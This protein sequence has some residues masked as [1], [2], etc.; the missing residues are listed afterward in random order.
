MLS[1]AAATDSVPRT[2]KHP[3]FVYVSSGE[4]REIGVYRMED[5]GTLRPLAR[6]AI[7]GIVGPL[8]VSP[9]RTHLYAACRSQPF[10]VHVYAIDA[11]TGALTHRSSAPL[12]NSFPYIAFDRTGRFLLGASY[13]GNLISVNA[14]DADGGVAAE[15]LQV[16]PVLSNAHSIRV[17]ESNRFIFVPALGTDRIYQFLFDE[18]SGRL[19]PNTPPFAQVQSNSGPRHFVTAADNRF[20]YVVN[21]MMAT[22]T[23]FA[24]DSATGLLSARSTA[25][26][27]PPDTPLVPGTARGPAVPAV[28]GGNPETGP[29]NTDNDIWAAD[30]H[31]SPDGKF[32]YISERTLSTIETLRVDGAT[33]ALTWLASTPTEKQ[34]RGFRIDARGRFMIVTGERSAT[35]SVYALDAPGGE[36]RFLARYPV[37]KGGNW[38][39]IVGLE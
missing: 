4:A 9:D 24:L 5:D 11:T 36:P 3:T 18:R 27:L 39:E 34:P 14:L 10:T 7:D 30:V 20:V 2:G 15:P 19:T 28:A 29:R 22:V 35:L 33:G 13:G 31:L 32:L 38:V 21:E 37:G 17:D 25:S 16:L 6:V 1:S 26:G 8:A 23:T 12:A